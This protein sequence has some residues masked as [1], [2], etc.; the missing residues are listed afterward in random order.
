[1]WSG[2][3]VESIT[4]V[5]ASSPSQSQLIV[6]YTAQLAGNTAG[7]RMS[8]QDLSC[9]ESLGSSA[10]LFFAQVV[11]LVT[12]CYAV[13]LFYECFTILAIHLLCVEEHPSD[14]FQGLPEVI[15]NCLLPILRI[16]NG[17]SPQD[18]LF[19]ENTL[20]QDIFLQ[21]RRF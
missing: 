20:C 17:V 12:V 6:K 3:A 16:C 10:A 9:F 1:M 18:I 4:D 21:E 7:L 19:P 13:G 14:R 15:L 5:Q 8:S 2:N 11:G